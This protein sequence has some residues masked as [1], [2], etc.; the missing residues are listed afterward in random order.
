MLP[1]RKSAS[2]ITANIKNYE[3]DYDKQ[4]KEKY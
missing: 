4:W 3:G 1:I 2:A